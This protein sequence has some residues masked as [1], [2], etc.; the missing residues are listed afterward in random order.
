VKRFVSVTA[1]LVIA[2]VVIAL[3]ATAATNKTTAKS[4]SITLQL[5]EKDVAFNFVDNPPRQGYNAPPLIGDQFAFTS[6]LLTRSGKH[7]GFLEATCMVARGGVRASGPCYGTF[8]LK[9][10]QLAGIATVLLNGNETTHVAIVGG[11]GA[12]EGASGSVLS[13]SRGEN[14]SFSD[15]TFHLLIP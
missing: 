9:G 12:Y 13:V 1:L 14:S 10:G 15:D 3:N 2:A 6:E 5:V 7:A 11:T 4:K 8:L